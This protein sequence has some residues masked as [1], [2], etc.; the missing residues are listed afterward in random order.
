MNLTNTEL[1]EIEMI[2]IVYS[3]YLDFSKFETKSVD[4]YCEEFGSK[5]YIKQNKKVTVYAPASV[6]KETESVSID[7]K[8]YIIEFLDKD[9]QPLMRT[10]SKAYEDVVGLNS[11]KGFILD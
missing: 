4:Y 5:V 10:Y 8:G 11:I 6:L 1:R 7:V 3:G 9:K 2:N